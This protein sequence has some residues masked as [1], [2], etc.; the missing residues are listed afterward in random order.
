MKYKKFKRKTLISTL[1]LVPILG[2]YTLL[3]CLVNNMVK[4]TYASTFSFG[5]GYGFVWKHQN[6]YDLPEYLQKYVD[7]HE[8]V[9]LQEGTLVDEKKSEFKAYSVQEEVLRKD[10]AMEMLIQKEDPTKERETKINQMLLFLY[11]IEYFKG[12]YNPFYIK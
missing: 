12:V 10:I 11:D 6:Y 5:K 7:I 8:N 9:H 4:T 1:L 3:Y 2:L